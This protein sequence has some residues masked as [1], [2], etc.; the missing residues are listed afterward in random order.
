MRISLTA[1]TKLIILSRI[2]SSFSTITSSMK[3]RIWQWSSYETHSSTWTKSRI[4][5]RPKSSGDC[6]AREP[7]LKNHLQLRRLSRRALNQPLSRQVNRSRLLRFCHPFSKS[8]LWVI[9][10]L[11]QSIQVL[12]LLQRKQI[13]TMIKMILP[14][15]IQRNWKTCWRKLKSM[16]MGSHS[17]STR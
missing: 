5:M 8:G 1:S 12:F 17:V 9:M 11:R 15:L 3:K 2:R 7:L 13:Q 10:R 16:K 14:S 4:S 6:L